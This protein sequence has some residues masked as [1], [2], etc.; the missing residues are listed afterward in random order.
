MLQPVPESGTIGGAGGTPAR[1]ANKPPQSKGGFSMTNILHMTAAEQHI[2]L[3]G[4][5]P[6]ERSAL[7]VEL[8]SSATPEIRGEMLALAHNMAE[9]S[10]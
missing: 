4:M 9:V 1:S 2:A 3:A 7:A 6:A 10:K 8:F 5:T